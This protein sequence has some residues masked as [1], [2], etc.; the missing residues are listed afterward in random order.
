MH[1]L[2]GISDIL[3]SETFVFKGH[4]SEKVVKDITG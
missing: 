4:V 2:Y 1:G 3:P